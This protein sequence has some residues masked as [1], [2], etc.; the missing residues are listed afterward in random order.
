MPLTKNV[1]LFLVF[2]MLLLCSLSGCIFDNLFG[3][4]SFSLSS[5]SVCDDDGFPGIS[6]I[7]SCSGTVTVKLLGPDSKLLDS[8]SFFK[9]DHN[10]IFHL[11]EY[12]RSVTPGSYKLRA[13]DKDNKEIKSETFSFTGVDLSILSCDQKWWK[14]EVWF[15]GYS[16]FGLG[17]NVQNNGDTPAYPYD[18][19]ATMDSK[20]ITGLALPTVILP[21]ESKNVDCFVYRDKSPTNS[22][23]TLNLKDVEGN[24]LANG[25]YSV[26]VVNNVPVQQFSWR[27]SNG[28]RRVNIP[29]SEYLYDYYIGLNRTNNED[30]SL[31][32]FD[33]YDDQYVDIVIDAI[34]FGF[35]GATDLEKINFIASFVQSLEYKSDSSTDSSYEYPRYP[36]ETLFNG[37][38]GGDCED[39]AILVA[40]L[41]KNLEY[42]VSLLRFPN[43]MAVGVNL[44]KSANPVYD[45]YVDGYFFLETTTEGKPCGFVPSEYRESVSEVSVYPVSSRPLLIH[46]W[47]N[48]SITIFTNTERGDFVKVTL[49]LE[50]L[51]IDTAKNIVVEGG[52]FT[53][54][55]I[56]INYKNTTISSLDPGVKKR[57]T[58]SVDIPKS[59]TT[60]FKTRIYL[61]GKVVDEK[62]S[63]SSFP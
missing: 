20:I 45:Y 35:G 19:S 13:Y 3:G 63:A 32:V 23:F 44:S 33:P 50:N 18:I 4:T 17:L 25:A 48:S 39:K 2:V 47:Q 28:V 41:L 43:H 53:S 54:N 61:D 58:L 15:G 55:E 6:F 34:M 7:F 1:V 27:Y 8:D 49:I 31:Y 10:A 14:R 30:Y 24:V 57:V 11:A 9:G 38:G 22:E 56:K 46:N 62:E 37:N 36:I 29:R 16:L 59:Y 42:N 52:F 12:R 21:E 26:N 51:G 5:W 40:S 60:L